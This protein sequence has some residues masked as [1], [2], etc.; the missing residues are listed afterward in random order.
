EGRRCQKVFDI[1]IE[2]AS[3]DR[4]PPV[5]GKDVRTRRATEQIV[6][7]RSINYAERIPTLVE[8]VGG[9][10]PVSDD[11]A[12]HSFLQKVAGGPEGQVVRRLELI[13]DG[14]VEDAIGLFKLSIVGV[15]RGAPTY[16][17]TDY[18]GDPWLG[19]VGIRQKLRPGE[20]RKKTEPVREA[21]GELQDER[22]VSGIAVMQPHAGLAQID[23]LRPA[24]QRL[25]EGRIGAEQIREVGERRAKAERLNSGRRD[26]LGEE[27]AEIRVLRVDLL[28]VYAIRRKVSTF[29]ARVSGV[30]DHIPRK[31]AGDREVPTHG[32]G[33]LLEFRRHP[34]ADAAGRTEPRIDE[35]RGLPGRPFARPVE[36]RRHAGIRGDEVRSIGESVVR[37]AQSGRLFGSIEDSETSADYRVCPDSVSEAGARTP[38]IR[39]RPQSA[40]AKAARAVAEEGHRTRASAAGRVGH[41]GVEQREL[42]MSLSDAHVEL[43]ANT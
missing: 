6:K 24:A 19:R 36:R 33:N 29:A 32:A 20:V 26:W 38:R 3:D 27:T 30:D 37:A 16:P 1:G 2:A 31:S 39:V 8:G 4:R 11:V 14:K 22:L 23:V 25:T 34:E 12:D 42:V 10:R 28:V 7:V 40:C 17:G 9:E 41:R 43:I 5:R 15:L 18:A 35:R 21:F 13:H